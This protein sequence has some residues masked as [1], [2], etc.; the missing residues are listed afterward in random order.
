VRN[1]S[2]GRRPHCHHASQA[3]TT[4]RMFFSTPSSWVLGSWKP[5][6]IALVV[7]DHFFAQTASLRRA[8]RR[9][10]LPVSSGGR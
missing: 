10:G 9:R 1:L 7:K 5:I 2:N 6:S 4:S 3:V 8:L